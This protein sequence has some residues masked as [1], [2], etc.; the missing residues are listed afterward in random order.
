M[1]CM[2]KKSKQA[3]LNFH[4]PVC[5]SVRGQAD[6]DT[7]NFED[8]KSNLVGVFNIQNVVLVLEF[9]VKS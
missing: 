6:M 8:P 4:Q 2:S 3:F 9:I 1:C 7:I 5:L